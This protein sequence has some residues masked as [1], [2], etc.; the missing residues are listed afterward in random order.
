LVKA[1]G[2]ELFAE[3]LKVNGYLEYNENSTYYNISDNTVDSKTGLKYMDFKKN[4]MNIND[5]FPATFIIVTGGVDDTGDDIPEMKQKIIRNVFNNI[6]NKDGRM[7]KLVL[8]SK[9]MN[10]GVTLE[11][12][13]EVHILDVHYNLGKVDQVIGRAIRMCKHMNL[14]SDKYK[15]P[16]VNVYRYVVA[17]KDG[18]SSDETLY[19]KAE[20]KFILVK[21]VERILKEVAVDCPMLLQANKF[22][23]EIKQYEEWTKQYTDGA[24]FQMDVACKSKSVDVIGS[25]GDRKVLNGVI[26]LSWLK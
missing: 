7:I 25:D 21:N 17:M 26:N 8:G 18:L 23:E 3:V 20:M 16:K 1:G 12:T 11:N 19:K 2:M 22:P 5:F 13:R 15:F 6:E 4:K 24:P 10:E 14:V 9:V